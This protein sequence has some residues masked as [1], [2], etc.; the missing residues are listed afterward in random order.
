MSTTTTL[1]LSGP[2]VRSRRPATPKTRVALSARFL[3]SFEV[4]LDHR[5]V[6]LGTSRRTRVLLAYV[7]D[8][9]PLPIPRDVLMDV[10]WPDASPSAARN[11]LH[12]AMCAVRKALACAWDGPVIDCRGDVYQLSD[13]LEL[14]TDVDELARRCDLGAAAAGVGRLEEAV[15]EYEA[16][17]AVYGGDF[18]ADDPYLDWAVD[19][20][21]EAR[22]K[23]LTS[24]ERLG[25]LQLELGDVRQAVSLCAALLREEP[26][27]EAVA[28]RL[29]VAYARL[30][31]PHMALR[32]YDRI[33][34]VLRRE[35]G[36]EAAAETVAL[37]TQIRDRVPV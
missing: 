29:M 11:S 27:H 34:E 20:R 24:V 31:Q 13:R 30:G 15:A 4:T 26:C 21:E 16:A 32:Q 19:R 6:P 1:E 10:F 35:L 18:L 36:V 17:R 5:P 22:L 7:L 2:L 25:E 3:G 37:A 33:V 12:V 28:R 9:S 8:R 14:W 23:V